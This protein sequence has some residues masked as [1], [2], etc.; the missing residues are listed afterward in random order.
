MTKQLNPEEFN[1]LL[2]EVKEEIEDIIEA[3][4]A[5]NDFDIYELESKI[6]RL[7]DNRGLKNSCTMQHASIK[8][9]LKELETIDTVSKDCGNLEDMRS[10]DAD[11]FGVIVDEDSWLTP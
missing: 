5:V 4:D 11:D 9:M 3:L 1:E 10:A 7:W 6:K 2:D 8:G